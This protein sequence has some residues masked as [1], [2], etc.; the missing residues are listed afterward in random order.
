[1]ISK[2]LLFLGDTIDTESPSS[3]LRYI[4]IRVSVR[5]ELREYPTTQT[6]FKSKYGKNRIITPS[7]IRSHQ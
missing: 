1:M 3:R 6:T 2:A 7:S 5:D 4:A